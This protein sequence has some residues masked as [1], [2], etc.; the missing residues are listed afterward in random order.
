MIIVRTLLGAMF[1][2]ASLAYFFKF[3][4]PQP[5]PTGNVKVYMDG[6]STVPI[7][8]IIK[9][10]ELLCGIA[11]LVGR[12]VPLAVVI[13]FP[14]LINIILFHANLEPKQLP[15]IIGLLLADLFVAYY[16]RANYKGLFAAK[17][18]Q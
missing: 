6:I 10:L 4:G 5:A 11:L 17:P 9:V 3:G 16:Y 15:M 12:F 13:L 14:I 1:V 18:I 8:P 2:F 7:L